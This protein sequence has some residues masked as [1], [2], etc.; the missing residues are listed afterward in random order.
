MFVADTLSR[1]PSMTPADAD[2][3]FAQD[4]AVYVQSLIQSLPVTERQLEILKQHQAEDEVCQQVMMYCRSGWPS[5]QNLAGAVC[6]YY[7][8]ASELSVKDGLLLRGSRIPFSCPPPASLQVEV[9][10]PNYSAYIDVTIPY[11][12]VHN[13]TKWYSCCFAQC[14]MTNAARKTLLPWTIFDF[15]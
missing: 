11:S 2:T 12:S 6:R 8:V 7:P 9:G 10:G 13:R 3:S 15:W 14:F 4:T 5:K 1:A